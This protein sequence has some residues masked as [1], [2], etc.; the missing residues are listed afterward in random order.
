MQRHGW[1]R[2][3]DLSRGTQ[4]LEAAPWRSA[5]TSA[6]TVTTPD[7]AWRHGGSKSLY[8]NV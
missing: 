5:E 1:R 6:A 7:P 8:G 4:D 2:P 3:T